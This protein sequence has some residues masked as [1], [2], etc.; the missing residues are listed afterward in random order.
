MSRTPPSFISLPGA[1]SIVNFG[2]NQSP[3]IRNHTTR[4][5]VRSTAAS[6]CH[7]AVLIFR[8]FTARY[9]YRFLMQWCWALAAATC[10]CSRAP[11]QCAA[12]PHIGP[13]PSS[14]PM[15]AVSLSVASEASPCIMGIRVCS[16][17]VRAC[18]PEDTHPCTEYPQS[19][20]IICRR[21]LTSIF[22]GSASVPIVKQCLKTCLTRAGVYRC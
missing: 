7:L 2:A 17:Q 22:H 12:S 3:R 6:S 19:S 21:V 4:A 16:L 9:F 10:W 20:H 11:R 1:R 18:R 8:T 14:L 13:D 5:A 15:T